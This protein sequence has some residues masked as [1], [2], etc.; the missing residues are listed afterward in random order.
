MPKLLE[1]FRTEAKLQEKIDEYFN[2]AD[3]SKK[4]YSIARL[5][6][7]LGISRKT[8]YNYEE[9]DFYG[10]VIKGARD[11]IIATLEEKLLEYGTAGQIFLAKNY[12]YTDRQDVV[13]NNVNMNFE[14]KK[15]D[16]SKLSD[17][18]LDNLERIMAKANT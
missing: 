2:W 4:P 7:W 18:E 1:N 17:E 13:S 8:L 10:P 12:G 3:E 6:F 5:A 16:L 14:E 15:M 9:K 11:R